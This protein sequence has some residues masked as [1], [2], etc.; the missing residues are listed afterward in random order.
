MISTELNQQ[1]LLAQEKAAELVSASN[2]AVPL[3]DEIQDGSHLSLHSARS[4]PDEAY[5]F[6]QLALADALSDNGTESQNGY[7]L[8]G[9]NDADCSKKARLTAHFSGL[10]SALLALQAHD[11]VR[12]QGWCLVVLRL[13]DP[14]RSIA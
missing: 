5:P 7:R 1:C 2:S 4:L 14:D 12:R 11:Q 8:G 6:N 10:S 9:T 3:S 13:T